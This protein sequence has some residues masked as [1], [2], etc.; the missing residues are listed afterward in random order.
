MRSKNLTASDKKKSDKSLDLNMF[1][2][3]VRSKAYE[4]YIYRINNNI[5]GDEFVDWFKA[6]SEIKS[7]YKI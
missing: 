1:L 5:H 4:N 7:K 2:D 6:E 3:E